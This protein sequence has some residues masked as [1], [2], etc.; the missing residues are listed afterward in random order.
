MRIEKFSSPLFGA[1]LYNRVNVGKL[2]QGTNRYNDSEVSFVRI[3]PYNSDDIKALEKCSKYWQYSKF[4]TNIYHAANAMKNDSPYY[5]HNKVFAL[6]S[7]CD[8]FEKLDDEKILGLVHVSPFSDGSLFV[9][10]IQVKPDLI[11]ENKPEYKGAGTGILNSLKELTG[12]I[13]LFPSSDKSVR[14]FYEKNGFF[15]YPVGMNIYTWV[16]DI[17]PRF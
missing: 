6:T 10:H 5:K 4:T 11:Y 12:K 15:E 7:Q 16:K 9:E 2:Q 1:I 13:S 3:E 14:D 17:F 8:N